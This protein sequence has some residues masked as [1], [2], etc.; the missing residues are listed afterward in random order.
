MRRV[1]K[2]LVIFY[3]AQALLG[4]GFGVYVG[5]FHGDEADAYIRGL[6]ESINVAR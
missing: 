6:L 5:V 1:A 2:A 3:M 4:L